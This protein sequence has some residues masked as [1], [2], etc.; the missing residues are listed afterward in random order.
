MTTPPPPQPPQDPNGGY[1]YPSSGGPY[2]YPQDGTPGQQSPYGYPG[3]PG[4][5]GLPGYPGYA[6]QPG[7]PGQQNPYGVPGPGGPYDQGLGMP[8]RPFS[9][10]SAMW[11]HLGTLLA[12]TVGAFVTC[13]LSALAAWVVG[14][15]I[16]SGAR[17]PFTRQHATAALNMALTSLIISVAITVLSFVPIV[18]LVLVVAGIGWGIAVIVFMILATVAANKGLPYRYPSFLAFPMVSA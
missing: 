14:L 8:P 7:Q 11:A 10:S 5:P 2:G 6:A 17:D 13:G 1:G 16:R 4:Q 15:S 9:T 3:Q 18:G 12:L